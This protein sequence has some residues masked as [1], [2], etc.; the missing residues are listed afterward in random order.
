MS[1]IA[2]AG[3]I[4]TSNAFDFSDKPWNHYGEDLYGSPDGD[5][6]Y[7]QD[8]EDFYKDV[9]ED[10]NESVDQVSLDS[11]LTTQVSTSS[12]DSTSSDKS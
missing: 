8:Y 7:E 11:S 12:E 9:E 1:S 3:V 5:Y 6:S 4:S 2:T 10:V